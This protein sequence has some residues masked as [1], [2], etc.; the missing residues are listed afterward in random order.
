MNPLF[1]S[2]DHGSQADTEVYLH[3][4]EGH[5]Y[6]YDHSFDKLHQQNHQAAF[7]YRHVCQPWDILDDVEVD[8]DYLFARRWGVALCSDDDLML[9]RMN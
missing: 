1:H 8:L 7:R 5:W 6:A 9:I 2:L 4:R 3:G